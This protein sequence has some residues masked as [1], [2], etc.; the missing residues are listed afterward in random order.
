MA[1]RTT[2]RAVS[3]SSG[4]TEEKIHAPEVS[5]MTSMRDYI[6]KLMGVPGM[7]VLLMDAE[8]VLPTI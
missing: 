3:P 6:S 7:K 8:T 5:M 2:A 4:L 1:A